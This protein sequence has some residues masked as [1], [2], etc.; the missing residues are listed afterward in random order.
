MSAAGQMDTFL[1]VKGFKEIVPAVKKC[2]ASQ[3]GHIAVEY[4][5]RYG[6]VLNSPMAVVIQ[7]MV[8]CEVSGVLFTCDPVTNNPSVITIT[9]NY[10]LGETVV[11]GSVEPDTLKLRRKDSGKLVFD[12]CVIGSKHQRIVMQDSGGTVTEDL[13]ENSKNESCLSKEAAERL[14]K[15][16]LKIEKYYKSSRDIE[17]GILNDQIYILQSRPVTNAAAESDK[18]IQHEFDAPLRCENEYFTV[19][20]VGEVMPGASSPLGIEL[21]IKFFG[22]AIKKQA[23]ENGF[24]ENLFKS[25]F[26][27]S[28]VL[29]FSNHVHMSVVE[30]MTRYG[31]NTLMSKGFMVSIFG[32][33]LD[34]PDLLR[35]A[36]EKVREGGQQSLYFR[37]KLLWD[38]FSFDFD[39]QKIMKKFHDYHS[40]FLEWNTAKETFTALLN[41]CSDFEDAGKKHMK[42]TEMS[43]NWNTY[44]FWIL[45]QAKKNFDNDVYSDFARLLSTSSNVE[46]ANIP[47]AMQEVA[48]QIVKDIG[49]EK[50]NSMSIEEAEEWLQSSTSLAGYKFR[51]FLNRHGHRCL[52]EIDVYSITWGMDPKLLIKLLQNLVKTSDVEEVKKEEESTSK[53]IAQLQVPLDFTSKCFLRFVLPHCRRGIRGREITKSTVI[54][55]FD[56][57]RQGFWRMAKQ[58]VS[59]GRLPEKELLFFL[60]LDEINDLLNT[61]SPGIVQKAIHRKKLFPILDQYIF[62]EISKGI[63]KPLNYEEESS[64]SYEFIADLTMK[65][66]PVSQGMTK[67][68]ARVAMSLEEA[69][70]LKSGEILITYSTDIGWSP[71]F[72][73]ISGVVTELGG[74]ISHGAV[75]SRE[76]GLP[77]VVGLQGACKRFRTGDYVLLDGKKGILQRATLFYIKRFIFLKRIEMFQPSFTDVKPIWEPKEHNGKLTKKFKKIIED[78]YNAKLDGYEDF[79]KWSIGNFSDFW[80]EMWDFIGIISSERFHTVI[81]LDVPMHKARWYEGAKLNFAENLLKYRDDRIAMV[82]DGEDSIPKTVTFAEMYE[83]SK[84]YAAA[85]RKFGLKKGDVVACYMSNRM[86]AIFAMHAV[87]SIGGI[88]TG[89]LPLLAGNAV[90]SRFK[91]V[92]PRVLL[93]KDRFLQEGQEIKVLPNVKILADGLESLEKVLILPTNPDSRPDISG[94]RN[95]CF[96]DEFLKVGL[97]A[98]GSVPPMQFEQ[99][100]FSHPVLISYTSG[101]TSQPKA[102]IHGCGILM[103]VANVFGINF[104]TSVDDTWLSSSPVG[105][106]SWSIISSL[107]FFGEALVLFEGTPFLL[108]PTHIWD[109]IDK[110]K[111]SHIFFPANVI[112]EYQKRGYAPT[113]DHDLSSLK[114]LLA[115]GSVVKPRNMDYMNQILKDVS[116]AASYGCTELMGGCLVKEMSVPTYRGEINTPSLGVDVDVVDDSGKSVVGEVGEIVLPKP[117]PGLAVGLW[118]DKDGSAFQKKYFSTYKGIFAMGDYGIRNPITK[119]WIICCRSDETLKQRGCRFGSSEIYNVVEQFP[120]VRDSL[121]VS[122]YNKDMDETAV[123][124][125]KMRESYSFSEELVARIRKAIAKELTVRHVPDS[126][127]ETPEIP[128]NLNKKKMEITVKK[129]INRLPYNQDTIINPECL[130]FYQHVPVLHGRK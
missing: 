8:A 97:D 64:D 68:F 28:G 119:N 106:V 104:D 65:G 85:F 63:P 57:W 110:H 19:A 130:H 51:Q 107:H 34:D 122:H 117:I 30:M 41:A 20:N 17:W 36:E 93:T 56:H 29:P 73:I 54:K 14:A 26:F 102:L 70:H 6:Q 126:I 79:H 67:G 103:A 61:R 47:Q 33:V 114:L 39:L 22:N 53:I 62:P 5:R 12:S 9:A 44:M 116:F 23:L 112:D 101:T 111:I 96:L 3:F 50:F 13:E 115:G 89:A 125:M 7:E 2:W 16:S 95:S 55:C 71:Y 18:E 43:S 27:S 35:Y 100:S 31:L 98:D 10:G 120:E 46:S 83:N 74:L 78:K 123:L 84:L 127:I 88:W 77:C 32:R 11:S 82:Q 38:L 48:I 92:N 90:L 99:V 4:K 42:C 72:P 24:E 45:C 128:Y 121:C 80:A 118:G 40:S 49:S 37:L 69:A 60:T 91:Q 58:M 86:E 113:R 15:L 105:W 129:I 124:F 76:Y 66:V 52:K 94:I 81:D 108:S 25:N 87:T 109:L 21:S 1:G 59:E 75:V